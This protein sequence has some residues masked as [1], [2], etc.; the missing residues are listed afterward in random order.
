MI[1]DLEHEIDEINR[2]LAFMVPHKDLT[3]REVHRELYGN[4]YKSRTTPAH[5]KEMSRAAYDERKRQNEYFKVESPDYRAALLEKKRKQ[6]ALLKAKRAAEENTS[7]VPPGNSRWTYSEDDNARPAIEEQALPEP[8][9]S[10]IEL[11]DKE[12]RDSS[13]ACITCMENIA[14][15][16]SEECGHRVL[17]IECMKTLTNSSSNWA[18]K[19]P[20]CRCEMKTFSVLA[21]F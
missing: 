4:E 15:V 21:Y 11:E 12:C 6:R 3:I 17:C 19:C 20:A 16:R 13:N 1:F 8:K 9:R 2:R 5:Q 14:S 18:R 10:K 7:I